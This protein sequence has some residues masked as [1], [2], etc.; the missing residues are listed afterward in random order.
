MLV[1]LS[2]SMKQV[3]EYITKFILKKEIHKTIVNETLKG[4][5]LESFL[6][7]KNTKTKNFFEEMNALKSKINTMESRMRLLG[8]VWLNFT[9]IERNQPR[10]QNS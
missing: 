1:I 7:P 6:D 10:S 2:D 9:P 3:R 8:R 4:T 5:S